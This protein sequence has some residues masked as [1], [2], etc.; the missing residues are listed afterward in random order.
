MVMGVIAHGVS[1]RH[2]PQKLA[3][4]TVPSGTQHKVP[5]VRHQLIRV[6]LDIAQ[7]KALA[8]NP[9]KRLK[10][11]ILVEDLGARVPPVQGMIQPAC[12]IG[13]WRTRHLST[14][15]SAPQINSKSPDP[16]VFNGFTHSAANEFLWCN[17][18]KAVYFVRKSVYFVG[19]IPKGLFLPSIDGATVERPLMFAFRR[20]VCMLLIAVVASGALSSPV[21]RHTHAISDHDQPPSESK[22]H[23]HTHPHPHPHPHPHRHSRGHSHQHSHA[24]GHSHS[25]AHSRKGRISQADHDLS[26]A[27]VAATESVSTK[28]GPTLTGPVVVH[29]HLVWLGIPL[30]LP[31]SPVDSAD[32]PD[33]EDQWVP[34]LPELVLIPVETQPQAL[35]LGCDDVEKVAFA[36]VTPPRVVP[37]DISLLCDS[38]RRVRSGVLRI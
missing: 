27:A 11:G 32:H 19:S 35:N 4:L 20:T 37:P 10:V 25:V 16:F 3:H 22:T 28:S 31:P 9:F 29:F 5:V 30:T 13:S 6:Q 2:P 14:V 33:L 12:F 21:L 8:Q 24:H 34:L 26:S 23:S 17:D 18:R 1:C 36:T 38:A 15:A 7:L